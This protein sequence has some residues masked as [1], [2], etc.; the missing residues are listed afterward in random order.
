MPHSL[1][2]MRLQAGWTVVG[3]P[4]RCYS[5]ERGVLRA[6][7]DPCLFIWHHTVHG[8]NFILVHVDDV[9]L[10]ARDRAGVK[11]VKDIITSAYTIRNLGEVRDFLG[12]RITR[13]RA[14][15]TLTLTSPGYARALVGAHGLGSAN[16]T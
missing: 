4:L 12:M 9:L 8:E 7:A 10:S 3:Q 13:D 5:G 14:A 16:P 1:R 6:A 2:L 15:C 11:A